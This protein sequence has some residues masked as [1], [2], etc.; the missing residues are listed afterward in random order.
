MKMSLFLLIGGFLLVSC[1]P[2]KADQT[3]AQAKAQQSEVPKDYD[4]SKWDEVSLQDGVVLDLRYASKDNF[5]GKKIYPC[6]RCF[7]HPVLAQKVKSLQ[8]DIAERYG[9]SLK[10][11]DCYRP[12]PAQERLWAIKPDPNY[13]TDPKLGSM[14][15]RGLAID[16]TLVNEDGIEMDMGTPFDFFGKEAHSDYPHSS[17]EVNKNRKIL[18]KLMEL[19]G[20]KGIRTEWWHYS[21][22][23]VSSPLSDWEWGCP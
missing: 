2:K 8:K 13:V 23:S 18:R 7:L 20:L 19:H 22:Q 21:L 3:S 16:L 10:I 9:W 12:R 15:N 5:V 4:I 6:A 1:Q 14:H 17:S 11:F